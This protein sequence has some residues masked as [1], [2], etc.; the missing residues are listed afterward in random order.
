MQYFIILSHTLWVLQDWP[1]VLGWPSVRWLW[2][3]RS[4]LLRLTRVLLYV[5]KIDRGPSRWDCIL[6]G[7]SKSLIRKSALCYY[8]IEMWTA[9]NNHSQMW[10]IQTNAFS[11]FSSPCYLWYRRGLRLLQQLLLLF[12]VCGRWDGPGSAHYIPKALQGAH[13]HHL[14]I[15]STGEGFEKI[16]AKILMKF[17]TTRYIYSTSTT[18]S[19]YG[20]NK[21]AYYSLLFL[22]SFGN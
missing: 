17:R 21:K 14:W 16:N 6:N 10:C 2:V 13:N 8:I 4:P 9:P 20:R 19:C 11:S 22:L 3:S 12:I 7:D 5:W 1:S 15:T 18:P